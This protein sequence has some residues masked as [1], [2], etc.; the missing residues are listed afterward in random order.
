[1]LF[2]FPKGYWNRVWIGQIWCLGAKTRDE[3]DCFVEGMMSGV[4]ENG[5][6]SA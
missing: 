5:G 2:G 6:T 3:G 4:V 1:M